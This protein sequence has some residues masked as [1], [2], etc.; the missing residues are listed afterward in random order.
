VLSRRTQRREVRRRL[1]TR[2]AHTRLRFAIVTFH[3]RPFSICMTIIT[4]KFTILQHQR[5]VRL[6]E[7]GREKALSSSRQRPQHAKQRPAPV[8]PRGWRKLKRA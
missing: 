7:P 3:Y 4:S 1:S 5:E 8:P 2:T 6:L